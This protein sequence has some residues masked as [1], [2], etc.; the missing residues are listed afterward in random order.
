L[1]VVYCQICGFMFDAS[2]DYGKS[3]GRGDLIINCSSTR[4][5]GWSNQRQICAFCC[6]SEISPWCLSLLTLI[7]GV[8]DV[9]APL[10]Q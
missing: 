6:L 1:L 8:S 4:S 3:N 7:V 10:P 9:T 5:D 2:F